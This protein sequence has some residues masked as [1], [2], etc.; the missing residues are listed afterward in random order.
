MNGESYRLRHSKAR[1]Q[2][3]LAQQP[4][5]AVDPNTGEILDP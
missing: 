2:H 4:G 3:Q 1:R 5:I